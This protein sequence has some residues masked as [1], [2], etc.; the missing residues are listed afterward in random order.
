M[1]TLAR[2]EQELA[3]QQDD[4]STCNEMLA[5]DPS[6]ADAL[7]TI[8]VLEAAIADLNAR[9]ASKKAEQNAAPP[10]PP[11]S[12]QQPA[13]SP[14]KYDMSKHP[15]FRRASPEVPP[16]P[17]EEAVTVLNVKDVVMA[18]WSEDK[19]WY[20][21]TVVSKTGSS[22]DPVY[23][24]TFKGYNTTETK[25]K[26][27]VRAI[28]SKKRKADAPPA[29]VTEPSA[30]ASSVPQITKHNAVISAAPSV[31]T[32]LVKKKEPSKVSDGPTRLAPEPKKLKGNRAL[33]KQ[34]SSWQDFQKSGPKKPALGGGVKKMGKDSQFRTP[35]LPNAKGKTR[36]TLAPMIQANSTCTSW[37]HR[38]RQADAEGSDTHDMEI[39]QHGQPGLSIG[40][41]LANRS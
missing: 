4:L 28:E 5:L 3:Q 17:S 19:Q 8:P 25:R 33:D 24:V 34:K 14:A 32:S 35:D 36:I 39:R 37:F 9:I 41:S 30:Q 22:A 23:K 31:D 38:I 18:K 29:V 13:Q 6:S 27:E 40:R 20:Q 11:A 10:P 21:A 16:P 26:H 2:L 7:E 1:S 12:D 15:K